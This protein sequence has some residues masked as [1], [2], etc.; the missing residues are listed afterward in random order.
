MTKIRA[1]GAAVV[2]SAAIA[3][4]VFAQDVGVSGPGSRRGLE[5]SRGRIT[6]ATAFKAQEFGQ[7]C[8]GRLH[9]WSIGRDRSNVGGVEPSL[10]PSGS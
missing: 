1:L 7:P 10:R 4:P 3:S 8:P 6:P 5:P 9:G 2:L